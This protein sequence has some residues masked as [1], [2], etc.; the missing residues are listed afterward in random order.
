MHYVLTR[1]R[2]H[3]FSRWFQ[4]SMILKLWAWV[5]FDIQK[6]KPLFGHIWCW[7]LS[8]SWDVPKLLQIGYSKLNDKVGLGHLFVW[9]LKI[10]CPQDELKSLWFLFIL[11]TFIYSFYSFYSFYSS[12][13][14]PPAEGL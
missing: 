2:C 7:A 6:A 5:T 4:Y 3:G 1:G 11:Y 9:G 8:G 12:S 13:D 14:F 10:I